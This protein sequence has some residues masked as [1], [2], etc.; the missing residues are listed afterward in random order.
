M[1]T[2]GTYSRGAALQLDDSIPLTTLEY[3]VRPSPDQ[4]TTAGSSFLLL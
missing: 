4:T 3:E 1:L 2:S